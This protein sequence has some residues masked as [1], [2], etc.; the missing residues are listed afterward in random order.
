MSHARKKILCVEDDRE[1]AALNAEELVERGFGIRIAHNGQEGLF[2]ILKDKPD[3]VPSI[4]DGT[5]TIP[6]VKKVA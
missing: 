3:L 5:W 2:A 1:T 6:P 4:L